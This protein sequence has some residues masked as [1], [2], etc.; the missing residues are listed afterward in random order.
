[1]FWDFTQVPKSSPIR[2]QSGVYG[3]KVVRLASGFVYK[4]ILLDTRSNK[5]PIYTPYGD[6]LGDEQWNWLANELLP[7][8]DQEELLVP[9]LIILGSSI[10]ILPDDKF[11]EETWSEFILAREKLLQM[12]LQVQQVSNVLLL[13]GDVHSAEFLQASC[14]GS[15]SRLNEFT[16]SGLSHTVTYQLY[17]IPSSKNQNLHG[18]AAVDIN[19]DVSIAKM[20][21][22][23]WIFDFVNNLYVSIASHAYRKQR[24]GDYYQGLNF[25]ILDIESRV[26]GSHTVLM[27][28]M[29]HVGELVASR[30]LSLLQKTPD[31]T[32]VQQARAEILRLASSNYSSLEQEFKSNLED[33]AAKSLAEQLT[34]VLGGYHNAWSSCHPTSGRVPLWRKMLFNAVAAMFILLAIVLPLV[35]MIWLICASIWYVFYE[36]EQRRRE[37]LMKL[38]RKDD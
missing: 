21:S 24:Y 14:Q 3:S 20:K 26:D 38:H 18:A 11:L 25:G 4:I 36:S 15:T 1:L 17:P 12:L 7:S 10:Q 30:P 9:D 32:L 5:D 13:S 16:S 35:S 28:I 22:R 6:F 8:K 31:E 19:D 29:N 2:Q 27:K 34:H 23:G 37:R 33:E